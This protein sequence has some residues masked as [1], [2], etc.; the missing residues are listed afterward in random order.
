MIARSDSLI[1]ARQHP[2][3]S[4]V[5]SVEFSR[6]GGG[7]PTRCSAEEDRQLV[8]LEGPVAAGGLVGHHLVVRGAEFRDAVPKCGLG[9]G[10]SLPSRALIARLSE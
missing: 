7:G 6:R 5:R 8:P 2:S 3:I 1:C 10:E 9:G 4:A